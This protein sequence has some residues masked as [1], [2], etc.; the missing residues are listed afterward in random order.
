LSLSDDSNAPRKWVFPSNTTIAASGYLLLYCDA[1]SPVSGTNTGFGLGEKG[2]AV[3]LFHRPSAGGALLDG[4]RFGLQAADYSIGRVPN[5]AGNWTL[6]VP[7][8]GALTT[9]PAWADLARSKS[10]NGWPIPRTAVIGSRCTT[11]PI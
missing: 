10:T 5:G 4:V 7:T 6:T 11:A 2:D 3:L 8:P 1:G 9:R